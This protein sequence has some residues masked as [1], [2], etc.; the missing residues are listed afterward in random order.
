MV[1]EKLTDSRFNILKRKRKW[2]LERSQDRY[3][4]NDKE[5]TKTN[6]RMKS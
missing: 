6:A 4:D 3:R 2:K 1:Q 5:T